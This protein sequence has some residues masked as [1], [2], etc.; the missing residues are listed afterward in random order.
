MRERQAAMSFSISAAVER[1]GSVSMEMDGRKAKIA[2][3]LIDGKTADEVTKLTADYA[4][5]SAQLM[6]IEA[7]AFGKI[8]ATLKSNQQQKADQA[9]ELLAGAFATLGRGRA[10]MAGRGRGGRQ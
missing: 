10:G 1:M 3:A 2:G 6:K 8:W 4:E 5:M 7:D 9:F